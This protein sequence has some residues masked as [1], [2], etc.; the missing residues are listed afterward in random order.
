MH[1][2][3]PFSFLSLASY[4]DY[5]QSTSPLIPCLPALYKRTN[6]IIKIVFCCEFPFYSDK[7]NQ[8]GEEGYGSTGTIDGSPEIAPK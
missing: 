3:F 6:K 5:K 1:D 7:P 2:K 4:Q 8:A